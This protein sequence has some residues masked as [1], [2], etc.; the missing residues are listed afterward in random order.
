MGSIL[1]MVK[2]NASRAKYL[3][4]WNIYEMFYIVNKNGK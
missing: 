2:T 1:Q 3:A 4:G